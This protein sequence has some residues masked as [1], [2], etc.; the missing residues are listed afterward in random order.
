MAR[1]TKT[2]N[3]GQNIS[4]ED[5]GEPQYLDGAQM[6]FSVTAK[7]RGDNYGMSV[8]YFY[9]KADA[10]LFAEAKALS[11]ANAKLRSTVKRGHPIATK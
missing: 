9:S 2:V 10:R 7:K 8:A 3:V 5:Y 11:I 1:K 4:V 6:Q